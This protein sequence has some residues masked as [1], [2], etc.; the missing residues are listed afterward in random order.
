MSNI[1]VCLDC[2][3][4]VEESNGTVRVNYGFEEFICFDCAPRR[5]SL[6][7]VASLIRDAG[8]NAQVYM[9]GGNCG[10]I[11]I[12][13]PDAEGF[14]PTAG[15]AGNYSLDC[16]YYQE[17]AIGQDGSEDD[18]FYYHDYTHP[19]AW[20]EQ[21]VADAMIHAHKVYLSKVVA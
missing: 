5:F 7:K 10:T 1:Y 12:G 13:E 2:Y 11:Y 21:S 4:Q 17:F 15:G 20:S 9:T 8:F 18:F 3:K 19:N 6:S 14:Y 16:G